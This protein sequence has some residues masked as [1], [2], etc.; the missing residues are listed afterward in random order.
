[1]RV[2]GRLREVI[3]SATGDKFQKFAQSLTLEL[4]LVQAN[5]QLRDLK[6]RYSLG[7]VPRHDLELQLVDHD[8]G[9]EVRSIRGLSGGEKFL[10]SLA[11]ALAL[12]SLSANDCRIDSLF[13]DEGFGTLD[14]QSLD[15]AVSTLDALQA[16]GRQIGIISH[17]PGLAERV[18]VEIQIR[19]QASGRSS[20]RVVG[21]S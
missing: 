7:R 2:W 8:L 6:P 12:A 16:E 20:V 10:V 15:I 1:M 19:P 21:P 9:D 17:V 4:L 11:L 14:A 13:I 3:G 18:G 5:A